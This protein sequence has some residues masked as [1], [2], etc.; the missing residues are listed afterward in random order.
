MSV[1]SGSV[2]G[3]V[4]TGTTTYPTS[5]LRILIEEETVLRVRRF[6]LHRPLFSNFLIGV[7]IGVSH[8]NEF[9]PRDAFEI[10]LN[11]R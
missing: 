1:Y 5:S 9:V 2:T 11:S 8:K 7:I 4:Q 3:P 6:L 10:S